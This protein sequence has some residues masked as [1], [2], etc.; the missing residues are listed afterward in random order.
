[1]F[2]R[3]CGACVAIILLSTQAVAGT[4]SIDYNLTGLGG[5]VYRY[6]YTVHNNGPGPI[7]LFDIFFDPALYQ[8][9]SLSVVT[10]SP[11]SSQWSEIFLSSLPGIPAA[12]DAMAL[13]GGI[14]A[15]NT[16]SGFAVQFNWLGQG[17]PGSQPFEIQDPVSFAVLQSGATAPEPAAVWM[18]GIGLGYVARRAWQKRV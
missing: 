17:V 16:V 4:V 11:L 3:A 9:S 7:Q 14:P 18:L 12:F 8:E 13:N 1:M 6:N 10:P 15:E 5:N 2:F